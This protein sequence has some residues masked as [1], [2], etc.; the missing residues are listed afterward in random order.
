M[1]TIGSNAQLAPGLAAS[2]PYG[3]GLNPSTSLVASGSPA[4]CSTVV[5]SIDNPLGTQS[6]SLPVL[7]MTTAP[8]ANYP[9]GA[10]LPGYG[11]AGAGASGELLV[12]LST[13]AASWILPPWL[14]AGQ[15]STLPLSIPYDAAFLGV[16]LYFQGALIDFAPGAAVPIGLTSAVRWTLGY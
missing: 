9:C 3:C 10:P 12:D 15:P 1:Q 4:L 14:G 13:Q 5:F 6:F 8:L 2:T 7:V 11:M 16:S